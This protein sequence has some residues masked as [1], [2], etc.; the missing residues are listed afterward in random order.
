VNFFE[1]DAGG[2][3]P[4]PPPA[5]PARKPRNKRTLRIQR[6]AILIVALFVVVLLLTLWIRSCQHNQ[7]VSS[8]KDY[9]SGVQGLVT[10][11]NK[12]GQDLSAIVNNPR[13]Y[14]PAGLKAK[15][16]S[17]VNAQNDVAS[18]AQLLNPPGKLAGQN[19][20]FVQG[21]L[22]RAKGMQHMRDGILLAIVGKNKVTAN[23]LAALSGYF[24]GPDAYYTE[25]FY[26][27]TQNV[28][29]TDGVAGI[30]VPASTFF[31]NSSM[32]GPLKIQKMLKNIPGSVV[33][34]VHGVAV[35]SIAVK[36]GTATQ[37]LPPG[38]NTRVKASADMIFI[39]SVSNS[40]TV[41]ESGVPVTLTLQP[42]GGAQAQKISHTID[43]IVPGKTVQAQFTGY[44]IQPASLGRVSQLTAKAGPVPLEKNL[45]NNT[46]Q[47]KIVLTL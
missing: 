46:L 33:G 23:S 15:L 22:V 40:G 4:T 8:Y 31:L 1:D 14:T 11:S 21:M 10:D 16:Q 25:E 35:V 45:S 44:N 17:M 12:V 32:F 6:F 36:S 5:A 24:T 2:G 13:K 37:Q 39:V 20:I 3:V 42:P 9:L 27:Q 26:T 41:T 47:L 28:L 19:Q 38:R 7:K 43:G 29:K 18:R 34:G 30:T